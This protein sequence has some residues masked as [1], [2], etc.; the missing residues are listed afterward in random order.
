MSTEN[1]KKI[2]GFVYANN[3]PTEAGDR[4]RDTTITFFPDEDP[5][6]A[7]TH[8]STLVISD[9][10]VFTESEVMAIVETAKI[11]AMSAVN[12]MS[13]W[14]RGN[15]PVP[16]PVQFAIDKAIERRHGIVLDPA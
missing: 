6:S 8:R 11:E 7:T 10:R 13:E 1:T 2:E 4:L 14:H 5:D 9:E 15:G 3:I 16:P 12:R